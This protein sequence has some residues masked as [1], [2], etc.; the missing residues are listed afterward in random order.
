MNPRKIVSL[1]K[2]LIRIDSD[3]IED[4]CVFNEFTFLNLPFASAEEL[5]NEISYKTK[6]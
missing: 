5:L 1:I 6:K 4:I 3:D 2:E